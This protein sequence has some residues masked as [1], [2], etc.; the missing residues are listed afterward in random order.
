MVCRLI[1]LLFFPPT[2]FLSSPHHVFL[3]SLPFFSFQHY[4]DTSST[5]LILYYTCITKLVI[6]PPS[7]PIPV[8]L[9]LLIYRIV[10]VSSTLVRT[11]ACK[12]PGVNKNAS[13]Y[14]STTSEIQSRI[15]FTHAGH[16]Y[17]N[18]K[19]P[20]KETISKVDFG[21]NIL[22]ISFSSPPLS[23]VSRQSNLTF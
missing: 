6:S 3:S 11:L 12:I 1:P 22:S 23:R 19:Y 4:F 5:N 21:M 17:Y 14:T 18:E 8:S 16:V 20:D 9:P 2:Y 15:R 13:T 10:N 7:F